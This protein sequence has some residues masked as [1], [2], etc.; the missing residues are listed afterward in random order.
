[1]SRTPDWVECMWEVIDAHEYAEFAWGVNDCCIFAARCVDAMTGTLHEI[2][3]SEAY[4]DEASALAYI[5][6]H[7]SLADAL[8]HHLGEPVGGRALRGDVVM[9]ANGGTPCVGVCVGAT[10][11]C[12]GEN[13]MAYLPRSDITQRWAI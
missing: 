7:G 3:L 4:S 1:M 12:M 13:S 5:A 9:C 2:D 10:V 8:T 11:A 6:A